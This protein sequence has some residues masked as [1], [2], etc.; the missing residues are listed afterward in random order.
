MIRLNL[1]LFISS[2]VSVKPVRSR[3]HLLFCFHISIPSESK[4]HFTKVTL[5]KRFKNLLIGHVELLLNFLEYRIC[6]VLTLQLF[7]G[8]FT[9]QKI[10]QINFCNAGWATRDFR[11]NAENYWP[12]LGNRNWHI[13]G[14]VPSSLWKNPAAPNDNQFNPPRISPESH[15]P[16]EPRVEKYPIM[17]LLPWRHCSK[18]SQ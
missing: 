17:D 11:H 7:L 12:W 6:Q 14:C 16:T 2:I 13:C 3:W 4:V 8:I 5:Q 10:D 15:A 1:R 9:C 18:L